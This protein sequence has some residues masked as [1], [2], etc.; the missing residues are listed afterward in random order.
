MPFNFAQILSDSW[1]FVRNQK[2]V[3]VFF[4]I[5]TSII[6]F[7]TIFIGDNIFGKD[8]FIELRQNI[9][10]STQGLSNESI[11]VLYFFLFSSLLSL[12]I[13][14][15]FFLKIDHL[16]ANQYVSY[17]QLFIIAIKKLPIYLVSY[18]IVFSPLA[19]F[20]LTSLIIS[21]NFLAI[22]VL[23]FSLFILIRLSLLPYA[24][25]I[26][27]KGLSDVIRALWLQGKGQFS[28]LFLFCLLAFF[29]P[30][31]LTLLLSKNN[32]SQF[33]LIPVSN[34]LELFSLVFIYRFYTLFRQ[35]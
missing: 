28:S 6:Q 25:L 30:N 16:S 5:L 26:G 14:L 17:Q 13:N 10:N 11:G 2:Q 33:I 12:L 20:S 27:N 24:Y 15:C 4:I 34:G 3:F 19:I 29:L 23:V 9:S 35:I 32:I 8:I 7:L 21:A 22:L 1:N 31:A 18:L